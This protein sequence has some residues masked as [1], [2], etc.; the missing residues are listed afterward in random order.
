MPPRPGR[1]GR[2]ASRQSAWADGLDVPR[3]DLSILAALHLLLG[4]ALLAAPPQLRRALTFEVLFD[5]QLAG[6][7]FRTLWSA[8]FLLSGA[9]LVAA[10]TE[11]R[12]WTLQHLA[13][14]V[15]IPV[16]AMWTTGLALA[17]SR[18]PGSVTGPIVYGAVTLFHLTTAVQLWHRS[19]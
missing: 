13:W 5:G 12:S 18:S 3:I 15:A 10:C 7:E 2:L 16:M 14:G 11:I 6:V 9:L 17:L 8:A 1:L 19:T 4:L